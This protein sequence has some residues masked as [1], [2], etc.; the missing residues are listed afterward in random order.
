MGE[1][2]MELQK[3]A[4][5]AIRDTTAGCTAHSDTRTHT[6]THI[7]LRNYAQAHG[8]S[9]AMLYRGP[10]FATTNKSGFILCTFWCCCCC[11]FAV[12]SFGRRCVNPSETCKWIVFCVDNSSS[13]FRLHPFAGSCVYLDGETEIAMPTTWN[14]VWNGPLVASTN[15][16]HILLRA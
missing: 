16:S 9:Y 11:W 15:H 7:Y 13:Y 4:S 14:M 12:I 10:A 5:K 1:K 8:L 3:I 6:H 2:S